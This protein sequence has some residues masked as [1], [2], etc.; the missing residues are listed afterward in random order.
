MIKLKCTIDAHQVKA[1]LE[2]LGTEAPRASMRAINRTLESVNT[3][4]VRAIADD[5]GIAQKGV[6]AALKIY[7]ASTTSLR[8]SLQGTGKRIPLMDFA[9]RQ[10]K[11]GVTYRM[12]GVRRRIPSGFIATM[13]SGHK[14]VFTRAPGAKRLPIVE[15]FG[16]SVP[17]IFRKH[18]KESLRGVAAREL[19]K[20]LQHEIGFLL[21][22]GKR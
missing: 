18:I 21:T 8:G 15:K 10:T 1:G 11:Q 20:N 7:R 17:Y 13:R 6:R 5:L 19:F 4:A 22:S 2:A 12:A 14:G 3:Q 9:A 16:P